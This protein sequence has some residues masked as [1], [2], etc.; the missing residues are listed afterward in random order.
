MK[1]LLQALFCAIM[2][3][4][5]A[6]GIFSAAPVDELEFATQI[7]DL[8]KIEAEVVRCADGDT[9]TVIPKQ[10]KH[11]GKEM[12]VRTLLFDS[13]ESVKPGTKPMA[14]SKEASARH[15][16]LVMGKMVTLVF[17]KGNQQDH[18]GRYLAYVYVDG[19]SVGAQM[20]REGLGIVRYVETGTDTLY[21]QFK[22]AEQVAREQKKGVWSIPGYVKQGKGK[23]AYYDLRMAY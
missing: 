7:K 12:K 16:E 11:A 14:W 19:K 2:L 8:K 6:C 20:L 5:S 13:T 15:K 1:T 21:K 22:E 4:L 10:G 18:Y 9:L 23:E 17:D 3:F